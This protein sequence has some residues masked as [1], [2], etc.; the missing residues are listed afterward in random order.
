MTVPLLVPGG[1]AAGC[2]GWRIYVA[3]RVDKSN[4]PQWLSVPVSDDRTPKTQHL[5][6]IDRDVLNLIM[7]EDPRPPEII[8]DL[9]ARRALKRMPVPNTDEGDRI[10]TPHNIELVWPK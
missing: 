6:Q 10:I 8:L 2:S 3:L 4:G 7:E 9:I 1:S 5:V